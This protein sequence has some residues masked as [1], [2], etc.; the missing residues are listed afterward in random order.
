MNNGTKKCH[1]AALVLLNILMAVVILACIAGKTAGVYVSQGV[2]EIS[3]SDYVTSQ[4]AQAV[5]GILDYGTNGAL[6]GIQSDIERSDEV[7]SIAAKYTDA[8]VDGIWENKE[9]SELDVDIS[10]DVSSLINKVAADASSRLNLSSVAE[11]LLNKAVTS[12][13]TNVENAVKSYVSDIYD[14]V[15]AQ[16]ELPVK[17]YYVITLQAFFI[18]TIVLMVLLAVLMFLAAPV[19][20]LKI[21]EPVMCVVTGVL[22]YLLVNVVLNR[23]VID[24]GSKYIGRTASLATEPGQKVLIIMCVIAVAVFAVLALAD[25]FMAKREK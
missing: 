5:I 18:A 15:R 12:Q 21:A 20:V 23:I 2:L 10:E 22:Y 14:S 1:T 4:A 19:S 7:A 24:L 8:F 13:Q 17:L 16:A 25:A 9:F 3:N 6:S 11:L